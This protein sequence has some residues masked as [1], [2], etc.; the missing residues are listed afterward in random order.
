M[1]RA[2]YLASPPLVVAYALA[3]T[4]LIDFEKEP[5]GNRPD[6]SAVYLRDIWPSRDEIAELER[7]FV[8]PAMFKEVYS[9]IQNGSDYWNQLEV[10]DSQLYPW[11]SKS[12][13]VKSPP[14]FVNMTKEVKEVHSIR[15]AYVLLNLGDSVTTDHISPAG[16]ISRTSPAANYLTSRG[17]VPR[18]FNSYGAR[19]GN[20][21]VMARG[22][23]ANI[24]LVNKLVS[25]AGPK[26]KHILS[27]EVM[28]IFDAAERYKEAG[29]QVIVLAGK[30][31]GSG[32]SRDWAAKGP[33]MLGIRAV[34]AESYER[35]HRSN[36]VGM[37]IVPLEY[38]SG[39]TAETLGITGTETFNIIL[40][41]DL[42]TKQVVTI[43]LNN[44]KSFK[45]V[46]RFD[47]D[48]E[49]TYFRHGGILNYMIRQML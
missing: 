41:S 21:A 11:D 40:P 38:L 42:T 15:N 30:E 44:G 25:K 24:R 47:T 28:D 19:R 1:T 23:F 10:P 6:G 34:I 46:V 33:W 26:T 31:Y 35:I 12:T 27:G 7:T 48:V 29:H 18:E 2:N 4:L 36:L 43:Q 39:Q 8:L 9:R 32:S 45:A 22:T 20:D 13:Y 3:G 14:F 49:L 37:G 16:S 5:L 17:L